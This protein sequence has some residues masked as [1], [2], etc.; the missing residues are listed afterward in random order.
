MAT[1]VVQVRVLHLVAVV[2]GVVLVEMV[3]A[4]KA[5]AVAVQAVQEFMAVGALAE[6][7]LRAPARNTQAVLLDRHLTLSLTP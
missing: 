4:L 7:L 6:H 3:L 5:V 1:L 2:D